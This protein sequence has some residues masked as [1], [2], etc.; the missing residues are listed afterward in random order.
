MTGPSMAGWET[1]TLSVSRAG[2]SRSPYKQPLC[3]G[4]SSV[5]S[6][7]GSGQKYYQ[8]ESLLGWIGLI[9]VND[10]VMTM[11]IQTVSTEQYNNIIFITYNILTTIKCINSRH[12]QTKVVKSYKAR[13]IIKMHK[14][15][16]SVCPAARRLFWSFTSWLFSNFIVFFGFCFMK[17][18][19]K[20]SFKQ[21]TLLLSQGVLCC[22]N[23]GQ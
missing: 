19:G 20:G 11:K 5:W 9:S 3:R 23:L 15:S 7:P 16:Q 2:P 17:W 8:A 1:V 10:P 21:T 12:S 18:E 13:E 22:S 14:T 6:Q 4:K